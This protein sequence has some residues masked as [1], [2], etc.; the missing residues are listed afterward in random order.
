MWH[1][2]LVLALPS[3]AAA[4][5]M[6]RV[7]CLSADVRLTNYVTLS[8]ATVPF[9]RPSQKGLTV[10]RVGGMWEGVE[11]HLH[12][13]TIAVNQQKCGWG[14]ISNSRWPRMFW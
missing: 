6:R 2:L 10:G 7:F 14:D 13:G 4:T 5:P 9:S 8:D 1:T 12:A 11:L 3:A